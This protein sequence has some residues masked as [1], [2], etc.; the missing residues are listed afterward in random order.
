LILHQVRFLV[1]VM[2]SAFELRLRVL[3]ELT[4]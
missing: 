4:R 3:R 1:E 2:G